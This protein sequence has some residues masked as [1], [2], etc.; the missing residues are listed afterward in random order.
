MASDIEIITSALK[1]KIKEAEET[2]EEGSHL[3]EHTNECLWGTLFIFQD[4]CT[5]MNDTGEIGKDPSAWK[6][7]TDGEGPH[8]ECSICL[9]R[10]DEPL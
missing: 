3:L 9:K 2:Y 10:V 4:D 7:K 6:Y 5:H 1:E 8:F